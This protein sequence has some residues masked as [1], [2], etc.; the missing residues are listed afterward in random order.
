MEISHILW[1]VV[2]SLVL[3]VVYLFCSG[4][5]SDRFLMA[6]ESVLKSG[7]Y[8]LFPVD[9]DCIKVSIQ[10]RT[11][12]CL[13]AY[14]LTFYAMLPAGVLSTAQTQQQCSVY[15]SNPTTVFCLQL[16]PNNNV[17]S[18]AQTQ[19][20]YSVYSS[21]PKAVFY[22]QLKPNSSV[23]STAEIQQQCSVYS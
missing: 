22:L 6:V 19:Q 13:L 2:I 16:K 15:S 5:R 8:R 21:N 11:S 12:Q 9:Y 20:Q 3:S 17:L 1:S 23:L 10:F 4:P 14:T 18:T 7:V